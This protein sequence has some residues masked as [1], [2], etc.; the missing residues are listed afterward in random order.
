MVIATAGANGFPCWCF[1]WLGNECQ[2]DRNATAGFNDKPLMCR[3]NTDK[4]AYIAEVVAMR[5][6][7]GQFRN[8]FQFM[9]ETILSGIVPRCELYEVLRNRDI[10]PIFIGRRMRNVVEQL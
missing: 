6:Q 4:V 1:Q 10:A 2:A 3:L 9:A 8:N 7:R 5:A